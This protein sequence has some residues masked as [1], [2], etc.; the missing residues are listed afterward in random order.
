MKQKRQ[1]LGNLGIV[2][3]DKGKDVNGLFKQQK[4]TTL[5][6]SSDYEP[7][8]LSFKDEKELKIFDSSNHVDQSLPS[9]SLDSTNKIL[10]HIMNDGKNNTGVSS[11][12][13]SR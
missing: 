5:V 3:K 4:H 11:M 6:N 1:S 13:G 7:S 10:T 2:N 9:V 12:I 8:L